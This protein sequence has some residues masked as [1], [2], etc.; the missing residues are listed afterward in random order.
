MDVWT[1]AQEAGQPDST[2]SC[3]AGGPPDRPRR[4]GHREALRHRACRGFFDSPAQL[5]PRFATH[6][7]ADGADLRAIQE[8]LGHARLST[9]QK[10]TQVWLTDLIAIYDKGASQGLSRPAIC[11]I[12]SLVMSFDDPYTSEYWD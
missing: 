9:T 11:A 10:Y 12:F 3:H 2:M 6:L 5:S 7:L 8:L 1:A 4:A